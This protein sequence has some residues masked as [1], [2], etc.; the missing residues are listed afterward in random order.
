MSVS[1]FRRCIRPALRPTKNWSRPG[2]GTISSRPPRSASR[3][4][5]PLASGSA[6]A[7]MRSIWQ[8]RAFTAIAPIS[9]TLKALSPAG[10]R[11]LQAALP[12]PRRRRLR[13]RQRVE[14]QGADF[15][16]KRADFQPAQRLRG[17]KARPA[18]GRRAIVDLP[19]AEGVAGPVRPVQPV[20]LGDL[21][22]L[23]EHRGG[24]Q[25]SGLS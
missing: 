4:V 16:Q 13:L 5:T 18:E 25:P 10:T 6:P 23:T 19:L 12:V 17:G 24:K 1:T 21:E 2:S 11:I 15:R 8:G 3:R 22:L 9:S 7:P 14:Q 20:F